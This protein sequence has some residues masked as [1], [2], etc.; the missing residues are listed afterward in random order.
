MMLRK[1]ARWKFIVDS[2][3]LSDKNSLLLNHHCN[4]HEKYKKGCPICRNLN[5]K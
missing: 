1:I 4:K 2:V 5:A 3:S